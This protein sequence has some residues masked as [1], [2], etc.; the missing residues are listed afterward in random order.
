MTVQ[1]NYIRV[2]EGEPGAE[3]MSRVVDVIR[4]RCHIGLTA[5]SVSSL[6]WADLQN[7]ESK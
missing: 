7:Q 2:S 1:A 5:V 3:K 4:C 6:M